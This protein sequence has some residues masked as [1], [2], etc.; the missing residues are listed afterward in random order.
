LAYDKRGS[1]R[2]TRKNSF[3]MSAQASAST[4]P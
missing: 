2:R 3:S 4:P 1:H